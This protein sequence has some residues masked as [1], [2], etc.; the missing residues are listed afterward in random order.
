MELKTVYFKNTG[1]ENTEATLQ[2]VRQRA[3]ELGIKNI[4]IASNT[5]N[6]AVKAIDM[7]EGLRVIVVTHVTGFRE[8]NIQEFT[9]ENR[10]AIESKGGAI[11][12]AA[13]AFAGLST[14]TRNKYQMPG[15]GIVIAD[16][17]R[18]FGQGV[19]VAC[20]IA[21]MAADA[22]LVRT[23]EDVISI[24]GTSHGSDTAI[25]ITP[26]NTHRFFELKVREILCKPR[27]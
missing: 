24:G 7:L 20:E 16:T 18:I 26:V 10:K 12:T 19:K 2:I 1:I 15:L 5:G 21:L 27:L 13:H 11:I 9:D 17:L 8:P 22:G 25:V 23:D 14:A 3:S 6:S 4:V